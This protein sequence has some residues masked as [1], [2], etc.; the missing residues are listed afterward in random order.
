MWDRNSSHQPIHENLLSATT[1]VGTPAAPEP[2][3]TGCGEYGNFTLGLDDTTVESESKGTLMVPGIT[4]PY[5]H[6]S[7]QM[8]T[9]ICHKW[10]PYPS[11]SQSN[12][13][14]FIPIGTNLLPN[15]PF[16]S[17]LLPGEFGSGFWAS[18]RSLD[19]QRIP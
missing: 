4:N 15:T 2:V 9:R 17:T 19:V 18:I 8:A 6:L 12:V 14:I 5:H 1:R 13:A 7:T 11:M 16:A 10:E 3:A